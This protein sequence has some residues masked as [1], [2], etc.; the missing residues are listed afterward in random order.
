MEISRTLWYA[1]FVDAGVRNATAPEYYAVLPLTQRFRDRYD[2]AWRQ[3][4]NADCF[5][6]YLW[7]AENDEAPAGEWDAKIVETQPLSTSFVSLILSLIL[8]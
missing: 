6:I 1:Y 7:K 5:R 2:A 3:L 4:V 8:R